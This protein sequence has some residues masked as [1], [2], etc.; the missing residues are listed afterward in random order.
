[1]LKGFETEGNRIGGAMPL[2][3]AN[4]ISQLKD[5]E[6]IVSA[7][8]DRQRQESLYAGVPKDPAVNLYNIELKRIRENSIY[9]FH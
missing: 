7:A 9:S 2:E 5:R 3:S 1:M 8:F 6:Q 4:I